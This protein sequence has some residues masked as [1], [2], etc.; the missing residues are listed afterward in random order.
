MA[1]G[2][3]WRYERGHAGGSEE[4]WWISLYLGCL[5]LARFSRDIRIHGHTYMHFENGP[6]SRDLPFGDVGAWSIAPS[7]SSQACTLVLRAFRRHWYLAYYSF[8]LP[9]SAENLHE[10]T[11]CIK[12]GV[13][14]SE[15]VISYIRKSSLARAAT[16]QIRSNQG[17]HAWLV[18]QSRIP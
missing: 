12:N 16:S 14:I 13:F 11:P 5:D 15:S 8:S 10:G 7:R 9:E 3:R 17:Y 4:A 2:T 1:I 6:Y 18:H